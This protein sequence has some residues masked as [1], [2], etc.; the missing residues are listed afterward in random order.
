MTTLAKIIQDTKHYYD[1]KLAEHDATPAG[2]DWNG[3][4]SQELRFKTITQLCDTSVPFTLNDLGC[5]Y[6]ALYEYLSRQALQFHYRGLDISEAMI[7]KALEKFKG[8][9]NCVFT[10]K[11]G[12]DSADYTV[13]SGIFNVKQDCEDA[14]W[15]TYILSTLDAM[16]QASKIGFSFNCLTSYSD[17]EY[18]RDFLYYADPCF[19]FD[20][21]K[22][23]YSR[24]VALLHDYNLYEFTLIVRKIGS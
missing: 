23:R 3:V 2:V 12:L 21:C 18:M 19:L 4:E 1:A 7:I 14:A 6:G 22:K 17:A 5:G 9:K 16:D 11:A 10:S 15:L 20:Y 24:N 13:A 8:R